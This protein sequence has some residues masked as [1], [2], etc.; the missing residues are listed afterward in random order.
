ML[1]PRFSPATAFL[2]LA[3]AAAPAAAFDSA[4][5]DP[6]N[7]DQSGVALRGY[8]PVAYFTSGA[9]VKGEARFAQVYRDHRYL[10]ASEADRGAFA[11]DPE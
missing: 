8:D 1:R 2:A 6:V 9:P 7:S 5:A 10:F 11:A 3:L 4:S